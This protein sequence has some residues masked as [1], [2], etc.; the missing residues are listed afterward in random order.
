[1]KDGMSTWG[2]VGLIYHYNYKQI[3]ISFFD[4]LEKKNS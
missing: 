4:K 3:D 2:S 1:M